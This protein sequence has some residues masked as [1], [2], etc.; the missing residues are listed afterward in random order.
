VKELNLVVVHGKA[1]R[2]AEGNL[3]VLADEIF[4]KE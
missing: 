2:D 4:V 1:K 3:T